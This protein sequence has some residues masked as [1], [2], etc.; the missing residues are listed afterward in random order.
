MKTSSTQS[1]GETTATQQSM[2]SEQRF[3]FNPTRQRAAKSRL[4]A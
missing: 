4:I 2:P 1:K 3:F